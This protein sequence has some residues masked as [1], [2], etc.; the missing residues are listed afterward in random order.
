V[1]VE[2]KKTVT[3]PSLRGAWASSASMSGSTY[4]D[5][6]PNHHAKPAPPAGRHGGRMTDTYQSSANARIQAA[7]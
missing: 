6:C 3:N 7:G 4:I 5:T 2:S 1:W